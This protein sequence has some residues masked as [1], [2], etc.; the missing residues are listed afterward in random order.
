[1]LFAQTY[2]DEGNFIRNIETGKTIQMTRK[3]G[4][5]VTKVDYVVQEPGFPRPAKM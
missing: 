4:S 2:K 1:M 5:Y 3:A